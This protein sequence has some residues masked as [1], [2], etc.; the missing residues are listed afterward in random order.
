MNRSMYTELTRAHGIDGHGEATGV[1]FT[2]VGEGDLPTNQF[3]VSRDEA[4]DVIRMLA[5]AF[6]L[7]VEVHG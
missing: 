5:D 6:D 3:W 1:L 2:Q 4:P 7:D